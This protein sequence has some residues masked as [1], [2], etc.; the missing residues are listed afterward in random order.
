VVDETDATTAN[1]QRAAFGISSGAT[2]AL[3]QSS[4]VGVIEGDGEL[5]VAANDAFLTMLGYTQ[6]DVARG[7]LRWPQLTPAE[8]AAS[9]E[10][11]LGQL[12]A[13]GEQTPLEKEFLHRDGRR[14][15]V[16]V[17]AVRKT[18]VGW[19]AI[20][21]E[22]TDKRDRQAA[23]RLGERRYRSLAEAANA[24]VW[25]AAPDG[26]FAAPQAAWEAYTGQ[27]WAQQRGFGFT[28]AIHPNDR[29]DAVAAWRATVAGAR[30][31]ERRLSLWHAPSHRYRTCTM[32][33]F[34]VL[35]DRDR[36]QGWVGTVSD[37]H[38]E[39]R[40]QRADGLRIAIGELLRAGL[41]P[42]EL[43]DQLV[44]VPLP[45]F[46]DLC[47]LYL[48]DVGRRVAIA[49]VDHDVQEHLRALEQLEPLDARGMMPAARSARTGETVFVPVID[50]GQRSQVAGTPRV[51]ATVERLAMTS[52][53]AIPVHVAGRPVGAFLF[54][55]TATSGRTYEARDVELA[56]EIGERFAQLVEFQRLSEERRRMQGWIEVLARIGEL[57]VTDLD[58]DTRVQALP[59]V[60]LPALG[61]SCAV[62]LTEPDGQAVRLAAFANVRADVQDIIGTPDDWPAFPIDS[63]S[64]G[65]I[66]VRTSAT[67]LD[68]DH[69]VPGP[70]SHLEG[71]ALEAAQRVALGSVLAV[72]LLTPEGPLGALAFGYTRGRYRYSRGDI[73]LAEEVARRV[74]TLL[75]QAQRFEQER[76]N[77]ELLQRSFLPRSLPRLPRHEIAVRYV[78]GTAGLKVG[79]DWY[80]VVRLRDGRVVVAVGD[81]AG[82]GVAAAGTMG[83]VRTSLR[84]HAREAGGAADLLDRLN[85]Y[86]FDEEAHEMVT[87]AV[88]LIDPVGDTIECA[89]AGHPPPMVR[90][91]DGVRELVVP[92][93]PPLGVQR[94][95]YT[96]EEVPL[97]VDESL[98]VY[99]DGLIERRGESLDRGLERL[100]A[101]VGE[102]PEDVEPFASYV[103]G[104]LLHGAAP[105]DDVAIVAIRVARDPAH[106]H[107]S[108][109]PDV[110]ELRAL[111]EL[112]RRWARNVGLDDATA[113]DVV[114]VTSEAA[115]NAIEHARSPDDRVF[116]VTVDALDE[117]VDVEVRD[118]GQ[119]HE[120][121]PDHDGRGLVVMRALVDDLT[122]D[123]R[124]DGTVVRFRT[125]RHPHA[126]DAT[127]ATNATL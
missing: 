120:P 17:H 108:F 117:T 6:A 59:D 51:R 8:W 119:W 46:A 45:D 20:V 76:T 72:P 116:T 22:L 68:E 75:H 124:R 73:P 96:S 44:Q 105:A 114:L 54:A 100:R 34:P 106:L 95:R 80:D 66:A 127:D 74:T 5:I 58:V 107:M 52:A 33:G 104:R 98:L 10:I 63:A 30:R 90:G 28:D 2:T 93:G 53:I 126:A 11:A 18:P 62:Y 111:R 65:A 50:R 14:V 82:H 70:H 55:Y 88:L 113:D 16:L 67:Y 13:T 109:G 81:V 84:V 47:Y 25:N 24:V 56:E 97:L 69:A 41:P 85:Q 71:R 101:V 78:P 103:L 43:Y 122:I 89:L 12:V 4:S 31:Y 7:A 29:D 87:L 60:L 102:G 121:Q 110:S 9:D 27:A 125:A 112:L 83:R 61:D 118:Y 115:A 57:A 99:T 23:L 36:V 91:R 19:T 32:R 92:T 42:D 48:S 40:A 79:G 64:P 123:C 94:M 35:D 38:D 37:V 86:V 77:A 15:P 49:H 39:D 26:A 3:L 1:V 21:I